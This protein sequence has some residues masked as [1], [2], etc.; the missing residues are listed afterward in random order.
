MSTSS[1]VS[2]SVAKKV[3]VPSSENETF[4]TSTVQLLDALS[5]KRQVW[6]RTDFKKA[7]EGLYA[8][9]ADSYDVFNSKFL[10]GSDNDKRALRMD[11]ERRL[12]SA[13]VKVQRN[14]TTL[15]MFI[16]YV[17]NSDRNRSHGYAYV[18]K[19]AISHNV[20]PADLPAWI[21]NEGGIEEVKRKMVQSE[22]S[23]AKMAKLETAKTEVTAE[24]QQ[25]SLTP[26]AQFHMDGLS[27]NFALLL[28]KPQPNGMVSIVGSLSEL[29]E[30]LLNAMLLK[31]AK[32]KSAINERNTILSNETND[33]L[34]QSLS[35]P[36]NDNLAVNA[37]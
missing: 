1:T 5:E 7:N 11:L 18:L 14:S 22:E 26:L 13:N 25:T 3:F 12:K 20:A 35:S 2:T 27:G 16:R 24:L 8:L 17:F 36:A 31:M 34:G 32:R 9:L 19:A 28:A 6:E 29:D 37:A 33:L 21:V 10:K 30:V 4:A 15:T 23:K